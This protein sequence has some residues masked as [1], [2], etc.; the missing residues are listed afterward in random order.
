MSNFERRQFEEIPFEK[1]ETVFN[2]IKKYIYI[3]IL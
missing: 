2:G 3:N 1:L